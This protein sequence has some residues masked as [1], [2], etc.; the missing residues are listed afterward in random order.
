MLADGRFLVATRTVGAGSRK[1]G[2]NPTICLEIVGRDAPQS[3][4]SDSALQQVNQ[5]LNRLRERQANKKW[6]HT[7]Q[8]PMGQD[9]G[10]QCHYRP[11][12]LCP[13]S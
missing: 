8:N 1:L 12:Q 2:A 6:N 11:P 3:W 10:G 13:G 5:G 9:E 7:D 4:T